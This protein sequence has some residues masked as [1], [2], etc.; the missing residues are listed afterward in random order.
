[1]TA[2]I[3]VF[4]VLVTPLCSRKQKTHMEMTLAEA[5]RNF[6]KRRLV[7]KKQIERN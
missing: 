3:A 5:G 2:I 1:M 6:E 7:S 4:C